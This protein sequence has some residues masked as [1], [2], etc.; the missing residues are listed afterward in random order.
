MPIGNKKLTETVK[1]KIGEWC[2]NR[3]FDKLQ[4]I[5]GKP[6]GLCTCAGLCTC[7]E[8][9]QKNLSFLHPTN[10]KDLQ[11]QDVKTKEEL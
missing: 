10:L 11:K 4:H 6:E 9:N 7:S 8:N 3:G 2:G 1:G 5:S